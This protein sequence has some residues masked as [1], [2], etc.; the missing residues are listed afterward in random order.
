M[1][2]D[3]SIG[4]AITIAVAVLAIAGSGYMWMRGPSVVSF[5][6]L[7]LAYELTNRKAYR[8]TMA[9]MNGSEPLQRREEENGMPLPA[10]FELPTLRDI[11]LSMQEDARTRQL[12]GVCAMN[13]NIPVPVCYMPALYHERNLTLF[14]LKIVGF[15]EVDIS[16]FDGQNVVGRETSL[17]CNRGQSEYGVVR[18]KFVWVEFWDQLY[19]YHYLPVHGRMTRVVQHLAWLNEGYT[20]CDPLSNSVDAMSEMLVML[21]NEHMRLKS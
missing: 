4:Q 16:P 13:Y 21:I 9:Q 19:R 10:G 15:S 12:D 7:P 6:K 11:I 2:L 3:I 17:L 18:Y 8:L 1:R 20:I 14:N 5:R